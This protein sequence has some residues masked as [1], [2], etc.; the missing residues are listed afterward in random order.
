VKTLRL[1]AALA[2]LT[3][4]ASTTCAAVIDLSNALGPSGHYTSEAYYQGMLGGQP[5]TAAQ[6]VYAGQEDQLRLQGF[7]SELGGDIALGQIFYH[8]AYGI[9]PPPP[10]SALDLASGGSDLR[11]PSITP[12][13]LV[14]GASDVGH[15]G[16]GLTGASDFAG[17]GVTLTTSGNAGISGIFP[18]TAVP[19]ASTWVMM[20]IGFVGFGFMGWRGS[21]RIAARA[22]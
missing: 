20:A 15:T 22:A 1:S 13:G 3:L 8:I 17:A 5:M 14:T 18:A 7:L 12:S 19:E 11:P 10:P 16:A 6:Q 2:A 4:T 9:T 21:R